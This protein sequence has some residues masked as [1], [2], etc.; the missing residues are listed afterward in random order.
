MQAFSITRPF[1]VQNKF[2]VKP[3]HTNDFETLWLKRQS[4][5]KGMPGFVSFHYMRNVE[6]EGEYIAQTRW[7]DISDFRR[8]LNSPEFEANHRLKDQA[9]IQKMTDMLDTLPAT[10]I[11]E[12][13][14]SISNN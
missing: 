9:W 6:V 3:T 13:L 12:E 14:E 11:F 8:W 4:Y 5:L 2:K 10:S 1:V 7:N